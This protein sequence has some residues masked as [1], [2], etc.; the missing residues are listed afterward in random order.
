MYTGRRG[1]AIIGLGT[2][3]Y[4]MVRFFY[5][6]ICIVMS[7]GIIYVSS[8]TSQADALMKRL[9]LPMHFTRSNLFISTSAWL[10][11]ELNILGIRVSSL[12]RSA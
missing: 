7:S 2:Y 1:K 9:L 5:T 4:V 12:R 11:N 3:V 10:F 6:Q 8:L